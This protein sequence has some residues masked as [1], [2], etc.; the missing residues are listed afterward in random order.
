[1]TSNN[2]SI[3]RTTTQQRGRAVTPKSQSP[4]VYEQTEAETNARTN[5]PCSATA[6]N[7]N[8]LVF[9][10]IEQRQQL[11]LRQKSEQHRHE[12]AIEQLCQNIQEYQT[13]KSDKPSKL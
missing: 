10:H 4:R 3:A 9:K 6:K 2:R 1:M 12:L 8:E 13:I 11:G 5:W 7:K